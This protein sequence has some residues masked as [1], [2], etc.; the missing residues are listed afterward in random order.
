MT[1]EK[2]F[3][4]VQDSLL[5]PYDVCILLTVLHLEATRGKSARVQ[6]DMVKVGSSYNGFARYSLIHSFIVCSFHYIH[7]LFI[8]SL[9]VPG[10]N[11]I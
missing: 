10:T 11:D 5:R 4:S 7:S 9:C 2:G 1:N 3:Q 8:L 6:W